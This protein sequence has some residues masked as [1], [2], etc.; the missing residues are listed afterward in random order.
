LSAA[1]QLERYAAGAWW[2]QSLKLVGHVQNF[3][4]VLQPLKEKM[5][6]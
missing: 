1:A 6:I 2:G 4:E 5:R 3:Y